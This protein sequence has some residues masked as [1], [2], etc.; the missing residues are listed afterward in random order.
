MGYYG[1]L[2]LSISFPK[3][4]TTTKPLVNL[5]FP[6]L[7]K[8]NVH[9][10]LHFVGLYFDVVCIVSYNNNGYRLCLLEASVNS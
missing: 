10:T 6:Q 9:R 5:I 7:C 1:T 8:E 3:P 2:N 4:Y